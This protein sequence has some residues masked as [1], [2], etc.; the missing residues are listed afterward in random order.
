[1]ELGRLYPLTS[2]GSAVTVRFNLQD[3]SEFAYVRANFCERHPS[4]LLFLLG[5]D[6][7]AGLGPLK[8]IVYRYD[9]V[10]IGV[11]RD[12]LAE[13]P[14]VVSSNALSGIGDALWKKANP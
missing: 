4:G 6:V 2:D 5:L 11:D 13:P 7:V 8:L 3:G 1:M 14:F 12:R 9:G 10:E